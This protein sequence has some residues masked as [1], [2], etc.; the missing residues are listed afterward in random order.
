MLMYSGV[1]QKPKTVAKQGKGGKGKGSKA[2]G[3]AQEPAPA[4]PG[5]TGKDSLIMFFLKLSNGHL[6]PCMVYKLLKKL[7]QLILGTQ[8]K[9]QPCCTGHAD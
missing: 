9:T 4:A 6:F 7:L 5:I 3:A 8:V 1:L 2:A